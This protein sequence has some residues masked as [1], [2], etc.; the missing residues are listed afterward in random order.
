MFSKILI[1]NR[2]EIACRIIK[3]ARRMGIKTVAVYSDADRGARHVAMADEAVYIGGSPA[4]ES[5]LVVDRILGAAR[6]TGAQAIHP[7][8]G[9]LS[10]NAGFAEACAKAG[11]VFIGPPPAAIRA[12]GSKSEAKKIMEGAKVPL[13]PGYHGDDQS[14]E[15]LAKEAQRIG[16]PVL[17]KASAG[18]GG[19]GMRVVED[20]AKFADDHVLV[21]KYLTRPRHIE[22]QVF[23]DTHGNC[24]YLFER[25]CSIQR[26]HQKVIEEAP[27]PN[28][29]PARRRQMGEA[30][31]AAA[32]AIGYVGAGTVEFIANQDGSFYFM[33]MNTRLQVEHPV[34]EMITGQ[35]LV[36]WQLVVA[37]G[38]K[39]PLTQDELRIDG[40]AVEVRLY[41]E[42]PN[43]NFLPSTGTLV[44]LRLP[45]EGPHVRV[46]TGVREGDTVTPFYDPMI[47]KVIV[48]DRDR[49]SAMRRMA[50]LMG[51]TE[52]VGVTTNAALLKALC[53]HSAFVGGEVDTGFIERHRDELFAKAGTADDRAFAIAT[54]ARA[55]EWQPVSDDPWDQKNGFRLLDTGH[56]E[57]RWKDGDREVA[58]IA[59][60]LRSGTLELELPGG[61]VEASVQ[62]GDGRLAIRLGNDT[63]T[64]AVVR[65][66]AN[67]GGI[68]YTIFADGGSTRLR[69]VDPL[70][71]TQYEAVAAGEG[72]VRSPL[73]GKIIDLKVKAGDTVSRG[74][75]LLVLE[76]M[77]MEH[78]L[79][80]PADGTVKSVRYGVGEQVPEGAELV[81]FE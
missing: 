10:E 28:M 32:K 63:F 70:D 51:E 45:Q 36:E 80:A 79:A 33:E 77:K 57:V 34:T 75:P 49:T 78:T 27:A 40:H 30:A 47:A 24:L 25:D 38:G 69:L 15:L 44:H 50:A 5:Y 54:L 35:D 62:R 4:R 29:D 65:R 76:A 72:A 23:A 61:R 60:R 16:F 31:V 46:D 81:E 41:A 68:D 9:F 11:V 3:T 8:Y 71:V 48:H 43:R 55:A 67:D 17:I 52:V 20:G 26:R 14:P 18:G 56:D 2:G 22:I 21:E 74:Q 59:R 7:G 12:M 64:A 42:D 53:S 73:P 6:R 66:Q 37:A 13:V 58:V 39:M 19:K 1:A